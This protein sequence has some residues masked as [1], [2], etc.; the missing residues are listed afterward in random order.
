MLLN[1]VTGRVKLLA[2]IAILAALGAYVWT[3]NNQI[4]KLQTIATDQASQITGLQVEKESL[5]E[6]LR[7]Q[8]AAQENEVHRRRKLETDLVAANKE[9]EELRGIFGSHDFAKLLQRKPGLLTTR[10]RNATSELWVEFE[11]ASRD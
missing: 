11:E 7:R 4:D 10:M 2:G 6:R 8:S 3:L 5:N 1:L 9:L